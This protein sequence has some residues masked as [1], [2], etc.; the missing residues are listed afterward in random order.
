MKKNINNK[1]E[2]IKQ[3]KIIFII[4]SIV[5]C[6]SKC[7][8]YI[9]YHLCYMWK[10]VLVGIYFIGIYFLNQYKDITYNFF[11]NEFVKGITFYQFHNNLY[12]PLYV[13]EIVGF[14]LLLVFLIK[15]FRISDLKYQKINRIQNFIHVKEK[16][17]F[18]WRTRLLLNPKLAVW[19]WNKNG[20]GESVFKSDEFK[21][22]FES[23]LNR[24]LVDVEPLE[25]RN[26][27]IKLLV[28]SPRY[29]VPKKIVWKDE[30]MDCNSKF[31]LGENLKGKVIVDINKTPHILTGGTTGCGKSVLLDSLIYQSAKKGFIIVI[32]DPKQVDFKVWKNIEINSNRAFFNVNLN[33]Q[34]KVSSELKDILEDLKDIETEF[35]IRKIQFDNNDCRNI[36]SYNEK[37]SKQWKSINGEEYKPLS[38]IIFVFDEINEL[39]STKDKK[40]ASEIEN[41]LI[42]LATQG[43]ALGIHLILSTQRPDCDLLKGQ[44]KS[45][46]DVRICGRTAERGLSEIVLGKGNYNA[47]TLI[48]KKEVG[49]FITN[50]NDMFRGY[51]FDT[52]KELKKYRKEEEIDQ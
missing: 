22:S 8:I 48:G 49:L 52:E 46:L 12:L 2:K 34:I 45:N 1:F 15:Y 4:K 23:A 5:N 11:N 39:M 40:I 3:N 41:I 25:R 20:I 38:R 33:Q 35:A 43:R 9:I 14:I 37:M 19:Y 44:I 10:L 30:N 7:L 16:P 28:A 50:D 27:T 42:K 47:D 31:V 32:A 6:F 21:E 24:T 29:R 13:I 26:D 17:Y 18:K 36:N 51:F